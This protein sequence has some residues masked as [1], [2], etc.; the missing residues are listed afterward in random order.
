MTG[1][2]KQVMHERADELGRS[3]VDLDAILRDAD[4]RIRRRA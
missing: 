3:P 2:L 4:R 1:L